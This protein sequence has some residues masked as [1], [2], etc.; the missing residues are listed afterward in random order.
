M[1]RAMAIRPILSEKAH[2]LSHAGTYMFEV[3][4]DVNKLQ[5]KQAIELQ[6]SVEVA[7]VRSAR[8]QGKL[9][10]GLGARSRNIIGQR[11]D[12][13]RAYVSLKD[14][15]K[16]PIFDSLNAE[17]AHDHDHEDKPKTAKKAAKETK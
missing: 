17:E 5:V 10:R 7:G 4:Q 16:L 15:H 1:S 13:K 3:P 12:T 9:K 14:G 6:Y 11:P 2:N 8:L